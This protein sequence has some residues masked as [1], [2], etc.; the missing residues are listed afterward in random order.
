MEGQEKEGETQYEVEESEAEDTEEMSSDNLEDRPQP[1]CTAILGNKER[2]LEVLRLFAQAGEGHREKNE[3]NGQLGQ[4][5]EQTGQLQFLNGQESQ[6]HQSSRAYQQPGLSDLLLQTQIWLHSRQQP[7]LRRQPQHRPQHQPGQLQLQQQGL[8]QQHQG[9]QW[10]AY[11][12]DAAKRTGE[13]SSKNDYLDSLH[14]HVASSPSVERTQWPVPI[15][16][17]DA[18]VASIQPPIHTRS[19]HLSL[20]VSMTLAAAKVERVGA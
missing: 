10:D 18:L 6:Q 12:H 1:T 19:H 17:R 9:W 3:E 5:E 2:G 14:N 7:Q 16:I 8:E 4:H 13:Q 20:P 15:V 11:R